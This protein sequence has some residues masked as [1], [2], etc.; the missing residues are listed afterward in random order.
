MKFQ[1]FSSSQLLL[2]SICSQLS[3]FVFAGLAAGRAASDT[4][5]HVQAA[6]HAHNANI[7]QIYRFHDWKYTPRESSPK[8]RPRDLEIVLGE[9]HGGRQPA[10]KIL[11]AVI[12]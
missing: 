6:E 1:P 4:A 12:S 10:A 2:L 5:V 8:S 11:P 9:P 7:D 3:S